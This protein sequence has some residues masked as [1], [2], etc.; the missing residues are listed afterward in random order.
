MVRA[1]GF[2]ER[3]LDAQRRFGRLCYAR[4]KAQLFAQILPRIKERGTLRA[5]PQMLFGGGAARRIAL[6]I[7]PQ[8]FEFFASHRQHQYQELLKL[9]PVRGAQRA[10]ARRG[11]VRHISSFA[12]RRARARCSRER[13][14]PIGQSSN[15]AAS[16]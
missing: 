10:V 14:V 3:K 9:K 11:T 12:K 13:I 7:G 4:Q 8:R 5:V 2:A 6:K 16:S 1:N 15:R